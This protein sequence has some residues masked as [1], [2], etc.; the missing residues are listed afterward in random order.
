MSLSLESPRAWR[1]LEDS[2]NSILLNAWRCIV[3]YFRHGFW[4]KYK[5]E[6]WFMNHISW[7]EYHDHRHALF[8]PLTQKSAAIQTSREKWFHFPHF[9]CRED[10][11]RGWFHL[12][13]IWKCQKWIVQIGSH[14]RDKAPSRKHPYS[15]ILCMWNLCITHCIHRCLCPHKCWQY[16][17]LFYL[18]NLF[19]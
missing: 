5:Q 19:I 3:N 7:M 10:T 18:F 4:K 8:L 6:S 9:G 14:S 13:V 12:D 11:W 17:N 15:V 2:G 16:C 1:L